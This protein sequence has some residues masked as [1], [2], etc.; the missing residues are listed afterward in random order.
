MMEAFDQKYRK[1]VA[2]CKSCWSMDRLRCSLELRPRWPWICWN[3]RRNLEQTLR[4]TIFDQLNAIQPIKDEIEKYKTNP[5]LQSR[6]AKGNTFQSVHIVIHTETHVTGIR[7]IVVTRSKH[8]GGVEL[9][10]IRLLCRRR[11]RHH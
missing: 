4:T 8:T 5:R 2:N 7:K 9:V 3:T 1:Y 11:L 10:L 6:E